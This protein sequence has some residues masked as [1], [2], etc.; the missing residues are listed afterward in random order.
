[1]G[2]R[3]IRG[4]KAGVERESCIGTGGIWAR[5]NSGGVQPGGIRGG[6]HSVVS[7]RSRDAAGGSEICHEF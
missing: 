6:S 5:L 7:G 2:G 3:G 1:M 4:L